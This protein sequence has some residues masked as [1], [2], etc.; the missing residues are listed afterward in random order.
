MKAASLLLRIV[1]CCIAYL[2]CDASFSSPSN[3]VSVTAGRSAASC[4]E[5]VSVRI[6]CTSKARALSRVSRGGEERCQLQRRHTGELPCQ[7]GYL[8]TS[9][10]M[11]LSRVSDGGEERCQLLQ[12]LKCQFLFFCTSKESKLSTCSAGIKVR[13]GSSICTL[14][15]VQQAYK[16][17]STCSAGIEMSIITT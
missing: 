11:T 1:S 10:A 3:S 2:S 7:Y 8:C 15:P 17:L 9:K 12:L 6:R 4:S 13:A 14:V 16:K 5:G